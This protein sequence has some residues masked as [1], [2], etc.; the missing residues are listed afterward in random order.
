MSHSWW[1][2]LLD[3]RW[4]IKHVVRRSS[5]L[6]LPT[7]LNRQGL[8]VH[9]AVP[10]FAFLRWRLLWKDC[11][12]LRR[13][14]STHLWSLPNHSHRLRQYHRMPNACRMDFGIGT[15]DCY[16]ECCLAFVR[17][18][19]R[20]PSSKKIQPHRQ[21]KTPGKAQVRCIV[22]SVEKQCC[23]RWRKMQTLAKDLEN[24][25][26]PRRLGHHQMTV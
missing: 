19:E 26:C 18:V 6:L 1:N 13:P 17:A 16:P 9:P 15:M 20:A 22:S 3:E 25:P 23:R 7:S 12:D 4:Q 2:H 8:V 11:Q 21:G 14:R 24:C 5:S 10:H